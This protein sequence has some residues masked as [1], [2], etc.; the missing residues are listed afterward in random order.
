MPIH[1][2]ELPADA[3]CE[4][5]PMG[6]GGMTADPAG[7]PCQSCIAALYAE[8]E[9]EPCCES[10]GKPIYEWG[11]YGCQRCDARVRAGEHLHG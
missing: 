3:N 1:R 6:C 10:C 9:E 4:P 7:G 2:Y 11:D 5:C 8:D